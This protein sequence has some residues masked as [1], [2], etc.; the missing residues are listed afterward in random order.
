MKIGKDVLFKKNLWGC[1]KKEQIKMNDTGVFA[2]GWF[3]LSKT[4]SNT[5]N[6]FLLLY[7]LCVCLCISRY[8]YIYI[9]V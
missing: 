4:S 5:R 3:T 7:I 9:D 8:R 1:C 6:L 2:H